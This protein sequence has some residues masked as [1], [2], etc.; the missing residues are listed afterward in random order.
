MRDNLVDTSN[1]AEVLTNSEIT[2]AIDRVEELIDLG[3]FPRPLSSEP[4]IPWPVF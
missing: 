3:H 2:A 4:N 1:W